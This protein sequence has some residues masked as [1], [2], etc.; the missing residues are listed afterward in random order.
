M[1]A[2]TIL[3][4]LTFAAAIFVAI[5]G[6]PASGDLVLLVTLVWVLAIS[7]RLFASTNAPQPLVS[8]A[9]DAFSAP[10]GSRPC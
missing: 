4:L 3:T 8:T 2:V 9:S 6:L 1:S 5:V 7:R 10:S